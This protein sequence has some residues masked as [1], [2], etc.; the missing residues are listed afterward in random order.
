VKIRWGDVGVVEQV[1][2]SAVHRE[3]VTGFGRC[4]EIL[5]R[6]LVRIT[7]K[8]GYLFFRRRIEVFAGVE[9]E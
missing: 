4:D 2:G 5:L 1:L 3:T 9:A 8:Y 6:G 7:I